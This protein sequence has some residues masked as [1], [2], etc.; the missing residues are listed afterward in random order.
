MQEDPDKPISS[1]ADEGPAPSPNSS[2]AAAAPALAD[3]EDGGPADLDAKAQSASDE[4]AERPATDS[5]ESVLAPREESAIE[6]L[7]GTD[8]ILEKARSILEWARENLW[9]IDIA[10][11]FLIL[12]AALVPAAIFGPQIK[13]L[14]QTQIAPRAPYGSL[15]RAANA[16]GNIATPIA[17]FIVLQAS[18]IALGAF[19]RSSAIVAAAIS[20]LS[21]W[22]V[23]RLVTLVIRSEFW[24]RVAF[25]VAWPLAALD[26]FGLLDNV[27]DQ[28]EAFSFPLGENEAGQPISFSALDFV[29]T[30][31]TFGILFWLASTLNRFIQGRLE[32]VEELTPSLRA[33][34]FKILNVLMPILAFLMALQIVGFNLATLTVFGGAIGLGVGLGLQR[35]ISNFFAGFT[36]IA[37]K[38]IKPGDV[39][40]VADTFGWVTKMNARYVSVRT[41][42]GTSHLIPND[43]FIEDGVINWS[44]SDKVVRLHAGFGVAYSTRDLKA[45]KE[46]A[47]S[48][49]LT[50]DRVLDRPAPVCNLVE[51]GDSSVNFDLRFWIDDPRNGLANVRSTVMLALW[52]ALHDRGVEIPF[53]QRDL[54]IKSAPPEIFGAMVEAPSDNVEIGLATGS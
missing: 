20:L 16:F 21:A 26:A 2:D 43:K 34:V 6:E 40:E 8:A 31:I 38:S 33:L 13:K 50:V 3:V 42:D 29:R 19:G 54:H 46:M 17:L 7:I 53:P 5:L 25:Y 15:K 1:P 23:I 24:S 44:H 49:A 30:L 47:E 45:I 39:I 11:Q 14:I 37:D 4:G 32:Q 9:S 28:L 35:T 22:I 51:F 10:V 48:T 41:R 52:D 12:F 18:T 27:I 36:L